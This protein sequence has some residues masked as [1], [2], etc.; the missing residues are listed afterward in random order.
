MASITSVR[1][2]LGRVLSATEFAELT[3]RINWTAR[4]R[5]ENMPY[6]VA[7]FLDER[8]DGRDTFDMLPDGGIRFSPEVS[9]NLG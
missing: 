3:I 7:G 8:D 6:F 1:L 5:Q 4:E 9:A 2:R